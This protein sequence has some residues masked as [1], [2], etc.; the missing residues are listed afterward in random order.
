[1]TKGFLHCISVDKIKYDRKIK[2]YSSFSASPLSGLF[3]NDG[4]P[5][6]EYEKQ[7]YAQEISRVNQEDLI[8]IQM[9]QQ[10]TNFGYPYAGLGGFNRG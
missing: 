7:F 4:W 8:K 5:C 10:Q 1:M 2:S 6:T 9:V 3:G